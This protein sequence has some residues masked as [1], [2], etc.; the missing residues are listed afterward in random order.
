MANGLGADSPLACVSVSMAA[1]SAREPAGVFEFRCI[2]DD[3]SIARLR[4]AA[5]HQG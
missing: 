4:K 5:D 3:V 1:T 2:D